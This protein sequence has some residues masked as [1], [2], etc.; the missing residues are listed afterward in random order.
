M[1]LD[2]RI[3]GGTV[4]ERTARLNVSLLFPAASTVL[5]LQSGREKRAVLIDTIIQKREKDHIYFCEF[6]ELA[7]T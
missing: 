1:L 3:S 6:R 5:H 2:A 7:H 4:Y